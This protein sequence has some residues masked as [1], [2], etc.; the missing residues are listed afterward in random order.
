MAKEP[1]DKDMASVLDALIEKIGQ[2]QGGGMT[3]SDLERILEK[4]AGS[5]ADAM[6]MALIPEN[7]VSLG[8]S[9]Y[10]PEGEAKKPKLARKTI[11]CQREQKDHELTPDEVLAFNAI[12]ETCE[13]HGGRWWARIGRDGNSEVLVVYCEEAAD[14][15]MARD[16]PPL[17][18]ILYELKQGPTAVDLVALHKQLDAMKAQLAQ[19][20]AA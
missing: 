12:T 7:K 17:T 14:R 6:K 5:T 11:F 10:A 15:E 20:T 4:T 2:M 13:A 19:V 1:T 18:H 8:I 16:L 9:V 3:V